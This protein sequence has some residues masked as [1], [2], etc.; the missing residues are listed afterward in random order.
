[1]GS[2]RIVI[3]NLCEFF[4]IDEENEDLTVTKWLFSRLK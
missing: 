4:P 2:T 3:A 1:M